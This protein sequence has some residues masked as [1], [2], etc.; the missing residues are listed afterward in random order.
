MSEPSDITTRFAPDGRVWARPAA[1]DT[2]TDCCR[3]ANI[4]MPQHSPRTV[5]GLYLAT[6]LQ[7]TTRPLGN[8]DPF[9]GLGAFD[10]IF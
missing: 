7:Q 5:E 3:G 2:A 4:L 10:D 6:L 1:A 9:F 8:H